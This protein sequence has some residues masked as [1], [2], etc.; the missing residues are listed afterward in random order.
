M[1]KVEKSA[2]GSSLSQVTKT[3]RF[4]KSGSLF[5]SFLYLCVN[6]FLT[7]Q[8]NK[9]PIFIYSDVLIYNCKTQNVGRKKE[10]NRIP[11]LMNSKQ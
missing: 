3:D 9:E 2:D 6:L 5:F 4:T 1:R 11:H 10:K 7:T 8:V